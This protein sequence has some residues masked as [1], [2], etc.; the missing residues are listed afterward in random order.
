MTA[1]TTE[2]RANPTA[3]HLAK[4]DAWMQRLADET[5]QAAQSAD[6]TRYLTTLARFY[7]Y[8]AHNCALIAMQRPDARRVAGYRAWQSVGRQVKKGARGIA[9]LC[10]AP[11]KAKTQDGD[12][13]IIALRFRIGYVFDVADTEGAALP[14]LTI[15]AVEGD[16]YDALLRQL[17]GIAERGGLSVRFLHRLPGDANG[18][19][20]GDGRIDLCANRPDGNM[21][22]TLIHE[23]AQCDPL[24]SKPA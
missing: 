6:L 24:A 15:H 2:K 4:I 20:H 11:L 22:K 19:S 10:P 8:S 13:T 14:E 7:T 18:I 16:R 23:I 12:E 9:I 5:D 3:A 1:E 21:C 17:V